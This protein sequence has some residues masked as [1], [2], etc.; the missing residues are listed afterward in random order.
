[1]GKAYIKQIAYYVPEKVEFNPQN[2]LTKKTGILSR[3]ICGENEIASDLAIKACEKL[4]LKG[5][6]KAK[7]EY[8]LYCT[9]SPDYFLPT[10]ACILQGKLRLSETC[11]AMDFNLGCSGYI[12]GL[13]LAKGLIES[14]QVKNVLLITSETYSK[15]INPEDS[16]V[17]PLFGDGASATFIEAVDTDKEEGMNGF[18][19]GTR[20]NGY[21][22]LIVPV[23]GMRNRFGKVTIENYE[24]VFGAK[25]TNYDL[26]MDG[27]AITEF[28][29]DVVPDCVEQVLQ[30][31]GLRKNEIDY[32]VFH[33]ANKFMLN[34]LQQSCGLEDEHFWNDV[35][36]YGNTVS[37][38]VPIALCDLL[39]QKKNLVLRKVLLCGFGVGLSWGG[40]VV[41]LERY[42]I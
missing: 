24:G 15:Y 3:H 28:A 10:T 8:L 26:Y 38:S 27:E 40:C 14:G 5:V 17:K 36:N 9:Q 25:R 20:G 32:Y 19:F 1:M 22:K 13:G 6:D 18:V 4:F 11:G 21:D 41:G 37:S 12:Y 29:M 16:T 23:G 35:V 30:K 2:R 42:K 31:T 39:K 34:Y 7:V 33:Q